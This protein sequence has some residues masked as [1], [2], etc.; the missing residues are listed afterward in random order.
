MEQQLPPQQPPSPDQRPPTPTEAAK[1]FHSTWR[2]V[3][4]GTGQTIG[5]SVFTLYTAEQ[6]YDSLARGDKAGAILWGIPAI[7][8]ALGIPIR[9]IETAINVYRQQKTG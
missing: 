4:K 9:I 2:T 1:N 5:H 8:N 6:V 7:G 3:L